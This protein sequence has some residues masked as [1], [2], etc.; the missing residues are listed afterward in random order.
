VCAFDERF[1]PEKQ[2]GLILML[3]VLEHLPD[4]VGA[5]RHALNLLD[6]GG[7]LL[8][9]VPAFEILWTQHDD[10]NHHFTRYSKKSFRTVANE[11]RM[12]VRDLRYLFHWT[13][14]AKLAVRLKEALFPST[15][16]APRLPPRLINTALYEMTRLEQE[17][18]SRWRVPFGSS[19]M[20]LGG[21]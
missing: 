21:K 18:L 11:A 13:Y 8:V 17:W 2:Y 16:Q 4:P 1:R 14:P 6:D 15:P 12:N 9:T 20:A 7:T 19:L 5:L 10:L 3:D